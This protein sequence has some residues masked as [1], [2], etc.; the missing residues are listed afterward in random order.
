MTAQNLYSVITIMSFMIALP[1]AAAVEGPKVMPAFEKGISA[2]GGP[3]VGLW[4]KP[5]TSFPKEFNGG[6][7]F[8]GRSHYPLLGARFVA[9]WKL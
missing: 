9:G 3:K 7:F 6:N 4:D 2:M 8:V 1:L 5:A